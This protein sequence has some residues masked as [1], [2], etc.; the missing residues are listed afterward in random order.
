MLGVAL[1]AAAPAAGATQ[2]GV[3]ARDT[4]ARGCGAVAA[5]R[6]VPPILALDPRPRAPRV[7]AIQFKQDAANVR[8]YA[9]FRRKVECTI[10]TQVLPHRAHGR[11]N[12]VLLN[13]DLGLMTAAIGSRGRAARAL[14]A[15]PAADAACRGQGFPCVTVRLLSE[16]HD[17]Y[18]RPLAYYHRHLPGLNATSEVFVA[19]TDTF[20]RSFMTVL[21][22]V[23]RRHH[24]YVAA[25]NDQ[26][27]F[28]RTS[29]PAAVRALAD[30][31]RPRPRSVYVATS[32]RVGNVTFLWGPRNVRRHGPPMLRNVVARNLKVPLTPIE[33]ALALTPGPSTGP[34]ARANLRPYRLPGT[35]AHLGFATS[36]PAF[37]YGDLPAGTD[38]CTDTARWYMRCL[39]RLGADVVVQ[40][41]ANPGP[42]TG[43][44]GDGIEQW[45]P[46]SWM[47]STWRATTDPSVRFAYDVTP[48]LVGNLG[49]L[50]FDGQSAITQRGGTRGPG[51]HYLGNATFVPGE[52]RPD[53]TDEVGPKTE[54][55]AIAPWVARDGPR[56][57]L[58][59]LSARLAPGSGD[60]LENDYL[61][62]ALVADLP[63]PVDRR[64]RGCAGA[65]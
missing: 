25:S 55:V 54:F 31:D 3:S 48:M 46:L 29:D 6:S 62:T 56:G 42:W 27:P 64:R 50:V 5:R 58:R 24:L 59:A 44:D 39:D 34:A 52:D 60:R 7:F 13:E 53:L 35:R 21:S 12:V 16:L 10:R 4:A 15:R 36:L 30:P 43:P 65:R 23:A 22:D 18:A 63:L 61:E 45:Q 47:T 20:A 49:D 14:A 57:P 38:P 51:C 9:T 37:T 19:T 26:A 32:P 41:D 2:G 33:Q 11:P 40:A 8:T 28:R 1:L 17:A